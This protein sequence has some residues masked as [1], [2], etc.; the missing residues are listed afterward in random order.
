MRAADRVHERREPTGSADGR[1][2]QGTVD[3]FRTRWGKAPTAARTADGKPRAFGRGRRL[4]PSAGMG[5]TAM[6]GP[7]RG[8]TKTGGNRFWWG[9]GVPPSPRGLI[10]FS[11]MFSGL[12]AALSSSGKN[13]L[14]VLQ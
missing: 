4:R 13:L 2:Q 6:A 9:G 3:P 11:A 8:G 1:A 14:G 10:A 12:I 7:R 5:R